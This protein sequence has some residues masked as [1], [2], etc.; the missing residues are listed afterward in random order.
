M[1]FSKKDF[2]FAII[3]GLMTGLIVWRLM[4]FWNITRIANF[5]NPSYF[6]LVFFVP[7]LWIAGVWLGYFLGKWVSFF[8]QFGKFVAIGFTNA[9]IDFGVLNLLIAYTGQALGLSFSIFKGISFV[10]A[11][12]NSFF[13][14][15]YWA[16]EAGSSHGGKAE[17]IKFF[18]VNFVALAVNV[19]IASFVANGIDPFLGFSDKAWAN[20][21][22]V[23]AAAISLMFTFVG[24]RLI[25]FKKNE[26]VE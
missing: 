9:A 4:E 20:I 26:P 1:K 7:I 2:G 21:S 13:W 24:F 19:S 8:N 11:V 17:A 18:A 22:A 10:V 23:S 25:V 5:E 16:F 15:K 14:N 6:W 12:T 3:T